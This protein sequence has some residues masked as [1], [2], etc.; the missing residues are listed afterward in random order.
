MLYNTPE[1]EY[2]PS[3][4]ELPCSD[5]TPVDNE[6]QNLIPNLLKAILAL[7]WQNRWDWFFGVDMG[8]Y[9]RT[10]QIRRTPIIPDGF[11][12]LGVPRRKND[13]KGRLSYVLL[14]ENNIAP[15]LVLELVSQ[16]YGKEY[17]DKI[18]AYA[19][20]GVL[21]YVIYNPEYYQRDKHQ[22]FEVYRLEN[23]VYLLCSGEP[24]W[25][26]EIDLGIGRGQG[27]HE[28]WQR[29]WLYWFDEQGNRFPTPEEVAQ[30]ES[31]KAQQE[32]QQRELVEQQAAEMQALLQRYRDRFGELS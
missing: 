18:T 20:L 30:Q 3:S 25:M 24:V 13:P 17:E 2:L 4:E 8:I 28:G 12:S 16:T 14:E 22:P 5:D 27:V 15:I 23:G 32:R 1:Y 21:Y 19:R 26:P 10:G 7:I 11:L 9:D 6:L 29:E 31:I